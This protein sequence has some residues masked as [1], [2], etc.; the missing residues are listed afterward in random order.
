MRGEWLE[1]NAIWVFIASALLVTLLTIGGYAAL[2]GRA[3]DDVERCAGSFGWGVERYLGASFSPTHIVRFTYKL[4]DDRCAIWHFRDR[5][6]WGRVSIQKV[7][8]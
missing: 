1:K 6:E 2:R 7:A 3:G 5:N 8:P 4:G